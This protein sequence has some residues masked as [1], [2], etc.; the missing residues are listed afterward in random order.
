MGFDEKKGEDKKEATAVSETNKVADSDAETD[1]EGGGGRPM[2][3]S[4]FYTTEE[5]EDE[6]TANKIQLGPQVTL[7]EQF[8]KDKDDESLRRWKE[9]LLGSVDI[10]AVGGMISVPFV[11]VSV[12][13]PFFFFWQQEKPQSLFKCVRVNPVLGCP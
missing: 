1:N 10:N 13:F 7:K 5:E 4:S 3:E 11:A 2:S 12:P 6:D 8:E 9:Q